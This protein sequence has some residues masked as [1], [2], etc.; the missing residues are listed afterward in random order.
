MSFKNLYM[1][2][3]TLLGKQVWR[4]ISQSDSI[5]SRHFKIMY[6]SRCDIIDAKKY[7]NSRGGKD[8]NTTII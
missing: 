8:D 4:L 3:L 2:S 7:C 5:V 1:F 6:Y